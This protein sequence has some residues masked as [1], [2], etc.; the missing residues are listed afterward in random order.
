[1]AGHPSRTPIYDEEVEFVIRDG[2]LSVTEA[3]EAANRVAKKQFGRYYTSSD[4]SSLVTHE[5]LGLYEESLLSQLKQGFASED[6]A[7]VDMALGNFVGTKICDP[8]VGEGV[9]LTHAHEEMLR[10][11]DDIRTLLTR[12]GFEPKPQRVRE[13]LLEDRRA[14]SSYVAHHC[15][16]GVDSAEKP[17]S[18]LSKRLGVSY[19]TYSSNLKVGDS[20]VYPVQVEVVRRAAALFQSQLATLVRLRSANDT[21]EGDEAARSL[22]RWI[23]HEQSWQDSGAFCWLAEFPEVFFDCAGNPREDFGF[24][25]VLGNPPWEA[26]KPNDREFFSLYYRGFASLD[27]SNRDKIKHALLTRADISAA[28][29]IYLERL[30]R[31]TKRIRGGAYEHQRSKGAPGGDV[32]MYKIGFE[33]F[34]NIASRGGFVG[35]V[36]PVGLATDAGTMGLR[37]LIFSD[38]RLVSIWGFSPSAR[39]FPGTDASPAVTLFQKGGKTGDFKFAAGLSSLAE[40]DTLRNDSKI[41]QTAGFVAK[42]SPATLSIPSIRTAADLAFLEQIHRHPGLGAHREGNWNTRIARGLDETNERH[43]FG[44][45]ETS[46][47]FTKGADVFPFRIEQ[48]R[49]WVNEELYLKRDNDSKFSRVVWRDVARPTLKRRVFAALL[50]P[51]PAAGNSLNYLI[52][53]GSAAI[54]YFLTAVLNSLLIDYRVRLTTSNSHIN[55]FVVAQ[56]PV[57]RLDSGH[58]FDSIVETSMKLHQERDGSAPIRRKELALNGLI[59][60]AYGLDRRSFRCVLSRYDWLSSEERDEMLKGLEESA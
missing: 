12:N 24:D 13:L 31:F 10:I 17:L 23:G 39:L 45:K 47:P 55:Q 1:M 29:E 43:M 9:F 7:A 8:M 16:Y 32:N 46:I 38:A 25:V 3:L 42:V 21:G 6:Y 51:G 35:I 18:L 53:S 19:D 11:R 41:A 27:R 58:L 30:R 22:R 44:N 56:L 48:P 52:P 33:Q 4:V 49:L 50:P 2:E 57:P 36:T 15:L 5:V 54:G 60:A 59:A 26:V 28:Y 40:I 37:Q 20:V 14:F 34:Y